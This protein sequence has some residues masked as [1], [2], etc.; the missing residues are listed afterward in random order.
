MWESREVGESGVSLDFESRVGWVGF[1]AGGG[2]VDGCDG[3]VVVR[4]PCEYYLY[5]R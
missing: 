3:E 4:V 1:Y 5:R 2:G